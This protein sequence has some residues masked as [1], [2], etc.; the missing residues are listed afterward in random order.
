MAGKVIGKSLNHGF[1]GNFARNPDLIAATRPNNA[2]VNIVFGSAL[3]A[4]SAGGVIPIS[5][6]FTA[7]KFVGVAGS[8]H[9]S[10]FDYL[11]QNKGGEYAPKEAVTVIQRGSV[12]VI[13]SQGEPIVGGDV[14]VRTVTDKDAGKNIG[15]FEAVADGENS[16]KLDNAQWGGSAD[17]NGVAELV[18]LTRNRA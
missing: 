5:G 11:N 8:E 18:L 1:A 10:A 16:V 12:S 4:D 3:M 9:K 15:D 13:C 2:E 14:Y 17:V 6:D 7:D